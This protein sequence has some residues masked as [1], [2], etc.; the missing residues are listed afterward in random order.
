MA[1]GGEGEFELEPYEGQVDYLTNE[2]IVF[3]LSCRHVRP[4]STTRWCK[5]QQAIV[6]HSEQGISI[7]PENYIPN[8][9]NT[10]SNKYEYCDCDLGVGIVFDDIK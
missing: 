8:Y 6:L 7:N 2:M 10:F 9:S 5:F 4:Q 3:E 1:T